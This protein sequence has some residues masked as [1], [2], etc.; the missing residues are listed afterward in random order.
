ML[1]LHVKYRNPT[2]HSPKET[3]LQALPREVQKSSGKTRKEDV[4]SWSS[5]NYLT[6]GGTT[7]LQVRK[8]G[9]T[10]EFVSQKR[11]RTPVVLEP[12]QAL[13]SLLP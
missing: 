11:N 13:A 4:G 10:T 5:W 7:R 9:L 2:F 3:T 6:P 8:E 12:W 1:L